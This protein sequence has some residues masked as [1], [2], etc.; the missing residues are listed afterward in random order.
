MNEQQLKDFMAGL[1]E[2]NR[3]IW[4]EW[5]K[6]LQSNRLGG[7]EQMERLY[8]QNLE[9]M[10]NLIHQTLQA[11]AQWLDQWHEGLKQTPHA[12]APMLDIFDGVHN[13]MKAMLGHRVQMWDALLKQ[14]REMSFDKVP[15]VVLG[16]DTQNTLARIWEEFYQQAAAAQAQLSAPFAGSAAARPGAARPQPSAARP[17][18][19]APES[20]PAPQ[21]PA[22]P[23]PAAAQ[24]Q[25]APT[26]K[27]AGA[28]AKPAAA[29]APA[30]AQPA[31]AKTATAKPAAPKP[32]RKTGAARGGK[33]PAKGG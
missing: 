12:P 23:R 7:G 1:T 8:Q 25:T 10:E 15:S 16:P 13:T 14:A 29:K 33:K 24:P 6:N 31:K 11:E 32:V 20:Q 27:A 28:Q 17:Q 30:P 21:A 9:A 4:D 5:T 19:A 3:R 18:P 26:P 22:A 2:A